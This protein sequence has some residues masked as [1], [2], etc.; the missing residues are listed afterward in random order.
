MPDSSQSFGEVRTLIDD[1]FRVKPVLYW[2]DLTLTM[3]IAWG[4][5]S[6][7]FLAPTIGPKIFWIGISSFAFF[8]GLIFVH[9]IFHIRK[10]DLIGFRWVWNAVCGMAFFLPDYTYLPHSAHHRIATFSTIDDPEYAPAPFGRPMELLSSVVVLPFFPLILMAR[11]LLLGPISLLIRGRFR[12]W[13]LRHA[14]TLKMNVKYEWKNITVEDRRLSF[15]QDLGVVVWWSVFLYID[16]KID[17]GSLLLHWYAISLGMLFINSLRS[18][19]RHR[20]TNVSGNRVSYEEQLLDS[21]T[22]PE[23]SPLAMI[24]MPLG[25]RYHSVHHMFPMLPYHS[26]KEAH[27]RLVASLPRQHLYF[28]TLAPTFSV[29][30]MNFFKSL[31]VNQTA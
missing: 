12:E 27:E 3:S 13:V 16:F 23:F 5:A 7:A 2:I 6:A 4:S 31:R 28:K 22:I 15:W 24:F 30:L 10:E 14:S 25:L 1:L 17:R 11:G 9:E 29:A 21:L 18:M 26:L 8:R 20:Y 19:A